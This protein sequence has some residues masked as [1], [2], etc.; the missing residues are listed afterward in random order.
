MSSFNSLT[1]GSFPNLV[2]LKLDTVLF[3]NLAYAKSFTEK[4]CSLKQIFLQ[5]LTNLNF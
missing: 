3:P 2:L 5:S 4:F 1:L